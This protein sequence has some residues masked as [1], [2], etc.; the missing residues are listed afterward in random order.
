MRKLVIIGFLLALVSLAVWAEDTNVLPGYNGRFKGNF[1]IDPSVLFD[2][3]VDELALMRNE[4][5]AKYGRE[6]TT[7]KFRDY[8]SKLGWY[9]VNPKYSEKMVTAVDNENI[10]MIQSFEK[11]A[12]DE[13]SVRQKVMGK[14][15]YSDDLYSVVFTDNKSLLIRT[16]GGYYAEGANEM[17]AWSV[18]GDWIYCEKP[19]GNDYTQRIL[20]RLN[21]ATG[22]IQKMIVF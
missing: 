19:L 3:S 21:H 8:F 16:G 11:P 22:A 18:K 6:F 7:P 1:R 17:Y 9:R 13:K 4:V 5:V 2:K 10:Q 12:L 15:E 20:L 14:I